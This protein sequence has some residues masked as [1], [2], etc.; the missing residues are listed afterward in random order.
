MNGFSVREI[1]EEMTEEQIGMDS[2]DNIGMTE[3]TILFS[4]IDEPVPDDL[5][6]VIMAAYSLGSIALKNV[7]SILACK[8]KKY[9]S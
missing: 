4:Q 7:D 6:E 5:E 8:L 2:I 9:L 1:L 3:V